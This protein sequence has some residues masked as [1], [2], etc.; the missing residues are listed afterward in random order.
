MCQRVKPGESIETLQYLSAAANILVMHMLVF[1]LPD[2]VSDAARRAV[3]IWIE[4]IK[5]DTQQQKGFF[6]LFPLLII[7][8]CSVTLLSFML[9]LYDRRM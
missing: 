7:F 3:S 2:A 6:F 1:Q 9:A 5:Y 4:W 8:Q